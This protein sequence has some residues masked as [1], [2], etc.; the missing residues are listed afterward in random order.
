MFIVFFLLWIVFNERLTP[1]VALIGVVISALLY[2]F[3][4]KFMDYNPKKEWKAF[5]KFPKAI[6]YGLKLLFEIVKANF[7]VMYYILTPKYEVEPQ[8]IYFKTEL[9]SEVE[10]VVLA[11][12]I[13][14][15]P[16]T[17]TVSME[18]DLLCVHCLDKS[19]SDGL[20][21]SEFERLLKE[22]EDTD[23]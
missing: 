7:G 6:R 17:I 16:G 9:K 18:E 2:L 11:N 5:L 4:I 12:S 10:R 23:K 22:M 19:L 8:L 20:N 3:V 21:H 14:L 15:T 13:T 1:E